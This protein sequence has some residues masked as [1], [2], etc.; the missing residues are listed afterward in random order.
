MHQFF[1]SPFSLHHYVKDGDKALINERIKNVMCGNAKLGRPLRQIS[2]VFTRLFYSNGSCPYNLEELQ[3]D[4]LRYYTGDH[5]LFFCDYYIWTVLR[6]KVAP[7]SN[8]NAYIKGKGVLQEI[9]TLWSWFYPYRDFLNE[10]ELRNLTNLLVF[11]CH[12]LSFI[13]A[14]GRKYITMENILALRKFDAA[15]FETYFYLL[16]LMCAGADLTKKSLVKSGVKERIHLLYDYFTPNAIVRI[17]NN[18][19][20]AQAI[21][22][23]NQYDSLAYIVETTLRRWERPAETPLFRENLPLP[24]KFNG[25]NAIKRAHAMAEEMHEA[26]E[27][28]YNQQE[29][30]RNKEKG[31]IYWWPDKL[32]ACLKE[33]WKLFEAPIELSIRGKKHHNCVGSYAERVFSG[34]GRYGVDGEFLGFPFDG[35]TLL[36]YNRDATAELNFQYSGGKIVGSKVIQC[37]AKYNKNY[38]D[39]VPREILR[40]IQETCSRDDLIPYKTGRYVDLEEVSAKL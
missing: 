40:T 2:D 14:K 22:Q 38:D 28:I 36:I 26:A 11:E 6:G 4:Y 34:R 23:A 35:Y 15:R 9:E 32:T 30:E 31:R 5:V 8:A 17:I 3:K 25:I 16:A 33:D 12:P 39:S 19:L 21:D 18:G 37:K 7:F 29:L 20:A 10:T 1:T 13:L 24:R 27:K